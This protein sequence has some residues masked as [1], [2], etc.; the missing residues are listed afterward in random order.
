[1]RIWLNFGSLFL[2]SNMALLLT[3]LPVIYN[4]RLLVEVSFT[5]TVSKTSRPTAVEYEKLETEVIIDIHAVEISSV[6]VTPSAAS[7]H[8]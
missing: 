5:K 3:K 1:M 6:C 2:A 4:Q 7:K 8:F